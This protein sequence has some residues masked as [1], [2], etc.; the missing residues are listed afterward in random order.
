MQEYANF[1]IEV[2]KEAELIRKIVKEYFANN[3]IELDLYCKK[4]RCSIHQ[5]DH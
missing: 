3:N 4:T 1:T 2:F 5:L